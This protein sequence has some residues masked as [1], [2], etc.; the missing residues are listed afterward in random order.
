MT[1]TYEQAQ[2]TAHL[3]DCAFCA[4]HAHGAIR[5]C[6]TGRDLVGRAAA[7]QHRQR[8]IERLQRLQARKARGEYLDHRNFRELQRLDRVY[9]LYSVMSTDYCPSWTHDQG[10]PFHGE[11]CSPER[12]P[13]LRRQVLTDGAGR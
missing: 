12:D 2:L 6:P 3:D 4:A 11:G 7:A 10:C 13:V 1:T 8:E 5:A 9:G